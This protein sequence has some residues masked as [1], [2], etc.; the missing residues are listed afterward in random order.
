M[1]LLTGLA[2]V[3]PLLPTRTLRLSKHQAASW[4]LFLGVVRSPCSLHRHACITRL[5]ATHMHKEV[6]TEVRERVTELMFSVGC[7]F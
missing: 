2:Y 1:E 4:S 6:G 5:Y 3:Q 7:Q